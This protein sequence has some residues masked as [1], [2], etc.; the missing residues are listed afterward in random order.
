MKDRDKE[1]DIKKIARDIIMSLFIEDGD[2]TIFWT[3]DSKRPFGNSGGVERDVLEQLGIEIE[4]CQN[5]DH[6]LNG[7]T[8]AYEYAEEV[9]REAIPWLRSRLDETLFKGGA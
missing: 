6:A 7:E 9:F 5:C 8:E 4:R 3:Q 1:A 2:G